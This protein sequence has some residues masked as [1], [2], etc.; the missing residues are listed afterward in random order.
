ML[1]PFSLMCVKMIVSMVISDVDA[2]KAL[3]P[4]QIVSIIPSASAGRLSEDVPAHVMLPRYIQPR[5]FY[6]YT[7]FYILQSG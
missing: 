6:Y 5:R 1:A 3:V 2:G 4:V 7:S